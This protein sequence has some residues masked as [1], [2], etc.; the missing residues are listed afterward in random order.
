MLLGGG[1]FFKIVVVKM[2]IDYQKDVT[3]K[4]RRWLKRVCIFTKLFYDE[5]TT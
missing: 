1:R 4:A 5:D 2:P 3:K